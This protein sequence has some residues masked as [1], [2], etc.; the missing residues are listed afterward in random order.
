M[1]GF[2]ALVLGLSGLI[3]CASDCATASPEALAVNDPHEKTNR[4][5]LKLNGTIYKY[6][7]VPTAAVDATIDP[8]NQIAFKQHIWWSGTCEYFTLLDLKGKLT[9]PSRVSSAVPW[10]ITP[11]CAACTDRCAPSK[12]A[13]AAYKARICLTFDGEKGSRLP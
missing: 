2:Q 1:G 10:T 6:F 5:T 4:D 7:V 13:T 3:L 9:K 12:S 8:A 11:P